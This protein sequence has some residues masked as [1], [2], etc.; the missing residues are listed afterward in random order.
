LFGTISAL[1]NV[2][3]IIGP[4]S[5]LIPPVLFAASEGNWGMAALA[6]VV[7]LGVQQIDAYVISPFVLRRTVAIHPVSGI[8]G[9]LVFGALLGAPGVL[10]AMPLVIIVKALYEEVYLTGLKRPQADED[11]VIQVVS[12]GLSRSDDEPAKKLIE[13]VAVSS[14]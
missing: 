8:V 14:G 13:P 3:P 9:L 7:N 12:A 6:V 10:L 5:A 1:A 4:F 2:V 11:S